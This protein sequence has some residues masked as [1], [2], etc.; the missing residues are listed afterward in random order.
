MTEYHVPVLLEESVNALKITPEGIYID[1]TFG[2]GGHSRS[3]LKKLNAKG[4]LFAFDQDAD[5][6]PN[7]PDDDRLELVSSNFRYIARFMDWYGVSSIDGILADLGVSSHQLDYPERGFSFRYDAQLDMRMN[8][9]MELMAADVLRTYREEDLIRMFSD[10][11][12]VR[13]SRQ[14][15]RAIIKARSASEIR[16]T[17]MLNQILE[18]TAIGPKPKYFAQV[19]QALRMEVNDEIGALR[20]M[21]MSGAKLLKPGGRFV[22]ITYHSIED[23]QVKNFFKT[24]RFDGVVDKDEFGHIFRPFDLLDKKV[25]VPH[26][27]EVIRNPRARSAKM[28]VVEKI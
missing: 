16:T 3:I 8:A 24:G 27:D 23:R 19:Y 21:L 20:D 15:S 11:G 6:L 25:Y 9:D 26:E 17:F 10:F 5:V 14:L 18:T 1:V 2:A 12:E 28:R 7:V 22:V 13:N 4:R